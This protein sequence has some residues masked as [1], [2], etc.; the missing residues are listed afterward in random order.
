LLDQ[1]NVDLLKADFKECR[2]SSL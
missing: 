2:K 1:F